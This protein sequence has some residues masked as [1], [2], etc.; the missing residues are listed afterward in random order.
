MQDQPS[1][2][3][4]CCLK[5]TIRIGCIHCLP[6]LENTL[7]LVPKGFGSLFKSI[8]DNYKFE[9]ILLNGAE[10]EASLAPKLMICLCYFFC[11]LRTALAL[12]KATTACR[13]TFK[14]SPNEPARLARQWVKERG[15]I[16]R[17][18]IVHIFSGSFGSAVDTFLSRA[19]FIYL[20]ARLA[21]QWMKERGIIV[22]TLIVGFIYVTSHAKTFLYGIRSNG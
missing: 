16:V 22:C 21:R 12:I 8:T 10:L 5:Q 17:A 19:E 11:K 7:I 3:Q 18:L 15:I 9:N 13:A 4:A 20:A 6:L 2:R 1:M 14:H